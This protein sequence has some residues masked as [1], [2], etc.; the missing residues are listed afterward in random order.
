MLCVCVAAWLQE[1][2][3]ADMEAERDDAF[4]EIKQCKDRIK[5][6]QSALNAAA[7]SDQDDEFADDTDE[8][9]DVSVEESPVRLHP[10]SRSYSR[11]SRNSGYRET[12]G[13]RSAHYSGDDIEL[14]DPPSRYS[15]RSTATRDRNYGGDSDGSPVEVGKNSM[16]WRRHLIDSD[17]ENDGG[18]VT[19]SRY[20]SATKKSSASTL[21]DE[22]KYTK[23]SSYKSKYDED[24][25]DDGDRE[26]RRSARTR[27]YERTEEYDA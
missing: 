20:R 18:E 8:G 12:S 10:G 24:E 17:D 19:S 26:Y 22:E 2:A 6:L 23:S 9:S 4:A 5:A 16:S 25:E 21:S 27:R 11:N 14:D 7:G 1:R 3:L 15:R 13:R